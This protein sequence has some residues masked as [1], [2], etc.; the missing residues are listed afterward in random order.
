VRNQ[1][2][3]LGDVGGDSPDFVACE[4]IGSRATAGLILEIEVSE[5]RPDA[6]LHDEAGAVVLDGPRRREAAG[7]SYIKR[8]ASLKASSPRLVI[9]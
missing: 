4:Q 5:R 3:Q 2:R 9:R 8:K 1:S 6:V 7:H